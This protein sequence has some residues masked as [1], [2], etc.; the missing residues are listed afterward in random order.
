MKM[1]LSILAIILFLTSC[2]QDAYEK[3]EGQYSHMQ[4]EMVMATS[5][6]TKGNDWLSPPPSHPVGLLL[7]TQPIVVFS[8]STRVTKW[9]SLLDSIK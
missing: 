5:L 8:I 2:T 1:P 6:P 9:L 7:Q 3:G 4:A